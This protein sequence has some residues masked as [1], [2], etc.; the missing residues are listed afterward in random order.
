M[1]DEG[2]SGNGLK[3]KDFLEKPCQERKM[4]KFLSNGLE[5]VWGELEE[6]KCHPDRSR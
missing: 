1:W 6:E 3:R 5:E 4:F 2:M